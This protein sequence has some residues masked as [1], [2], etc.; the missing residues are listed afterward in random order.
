MTTDASASSDNRA[1]I[2]DQLDPQ[3]VLDSEVVFSGRVWDVRR[4][5]VRLPGE[6]EVVRELVVHPGAVG[7]IALDD[8]DRV[9]LVRQYRH[10]VGGYLWEAPAG[11]LDVQGEPP[12]V[13][14]QRE[15]YEEAH[16]RADTWHV[17]VDYYNS[18]GSSSEAF[19]C[20]LARDVAS[21]DGERYAADG[22]ERD[23]PLR[24]V[25]L[26]DAVTAV[27]RGD[28]HNPTTV[29]GVLATHAA[30]ALGWSNLRPPDAPWP[31]RF[32]DPLADA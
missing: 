10:P 23:M 15:L 5:T 12:L 28:L 31:E 30:R 13:T 14:A 3:P 11:L 26:D 19:R 22:E 24:W 6:S 27:F 32:P 17:L 20:Y 29:S 16:L 7:I 21:V 4:D 8:Q 1:A 9:A 25:D 2:T 18:P